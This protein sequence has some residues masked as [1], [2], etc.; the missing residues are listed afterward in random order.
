MRYDTKYLYF[1]PEYIKV[2]IP[3]FFLNL[4]IVFV[5]FCQVIGKC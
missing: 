5:C 2:L 4:E 1:L 3:H